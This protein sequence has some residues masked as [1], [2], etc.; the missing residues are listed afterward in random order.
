MTQESLQMNWPIGPRVQANALC[1]PQ[2]PALALSALPKDQ[3]PLGLSAMPKDNHAQLGDGQGP[4]LAMLAAS[5]RPLGY[6]TPAETPPTIA[7]PQL[8]QRPEPYLGRQVDRIRSELQA[9]LEEEAAL[10]GAVA[11]KRSL[12]VLQASRIAAL[13]RCTADLLR[14]RDAAIAVAVSSVAE[15]AYGIT[16]DRPRHLEPGQSN[17]ESARSAESPLAPSAVVAN[18]AGARIKRLREEGL[19]QGAEMEDEPDSPNGEYDV[20]SLEAATEQLGRL[21]E[22]QQQVACL[23]DELENRTSEVERLTAQIGALDAVASSRQK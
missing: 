3:G 19:A 7:A 13:E 1:A 22:L 9:S 20:Q 11:R 15:G 16:S 21:R 14:R 4:P 12:A 8:W 6:T 17:L 2:K 18:A 5:L 10:E 23:E